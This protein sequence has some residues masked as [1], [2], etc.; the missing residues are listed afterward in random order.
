[1]TIVGHASQ[2][3]ATLTE[4][5]HAKANYAISQARARQVVAALQGYGVS[6]GSMVVEALG[7]SQPIYG[8]FMPTGEAHNRRVEIY[9]N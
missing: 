2:H 5:Q 9:L 4:A 6:S 3:T 7:S 1:M 8:E